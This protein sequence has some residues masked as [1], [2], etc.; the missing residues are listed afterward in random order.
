MKFLSLFANLYV[1][2]HPYV[3]IV[4]VECTLKKAVAMGGGKLCFHPHFIALT[5]ANVTLFLEDEG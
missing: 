4:S 1:V 2:P 3:V 5:L